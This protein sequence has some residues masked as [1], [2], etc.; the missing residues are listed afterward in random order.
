MLTAGSE[1]TSLKLSEG[2]PPYT[3]Y[4]GPPFATGTPHYGP[5]CHLSIRPAAHSSPAAQ[6]LFVGA[7]YSDYAGHILAGTIKDVITRYWHANGR[8]VERRCA[9]RA[10]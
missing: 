5:P 4:D 9:H 1:Q 3:F 8:Y 2:R 10:R 6:V 7:V